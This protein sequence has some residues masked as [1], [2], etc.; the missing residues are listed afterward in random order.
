MINF[1]GLQQNTACMERIRAAGH[2]INYIDNTLH[3]SDEAAVQAII[4]AFTLEEAK[5][6][7][8]ARVLAHAK[9]LRDK[10]VASISPGEMASWSIKV[11]EAAKFRAS[12]DPAQC[13]MLSMEAQ[14][15]AITL[16]AL[17][18]K[19]EGNSAR[20]SSVEALIGG[21]DGKHRDAIAALTTFEAV[22]AY[23]FS[24]GWPDV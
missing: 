14:A 12:G 8:K 13:P 19:V 4:D 17:V 23:D 5:D 20:L 18:T 16:E 3:A 6:Y 22:A 2:W 9:A 15:R 21:N 7:A 11:S 24:T 10:V 1:K